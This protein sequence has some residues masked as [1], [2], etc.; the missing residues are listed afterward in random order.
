[1]ENERKKLLATAQELKNKGAEII[2]IGGGDPIEYGFINK[3]ASDALIQV[4]KKGLHMYSYWTNCLSDLK[5][6]I[7]EFEKKYRNVDYSHEDIILTPGVA[8]AFQ[9]IHYALLGAGDEIIT[10]EPTH[11]LTGPTSY[12]YIF[13]SK[14]VAVCTLEV[15][16]WK[17]N[18]EE[19]RERISK[20]TKA[21]VIVNPNNPTGSVYDEKTLRSIVDIAGEYCLPIISDEIYGL[22]TFGNVKA[23]SIAQVASDVPAIVLSGISKVFM[24]PGWR[25]GYIAIHDPQGKMAEIIK[26]AKA[27]SALYG[28]AT[29]CMATPILYASITAYKGSINEAQ[30][31]MQQ[32][33]VPR[34]FTV[35]R[36]NEI[37]GIM[38]TKPKGTFFAFPH[39]YA[40]DPHGKWKTDEDFLIE[41]L[42]EEHIL[43]SFPGS[44]FGNSG[45]GHFRTLLLPELKTLEEVYDRLE[46]FI[47][48]H[49]VSER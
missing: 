21:I 30:R 10:F 48:K 6:A 26:A 12:F 3:Y 23:K 37:Q 38:C 33:Q 19:L 35:K 5:K 17:P 20:R 41:L 11:Y 1:M 34:D 31:M 44:I 29:S 4:S 13:Q 7:V 45:Y 47:I 40:I 25:V 39:V 9:V 49:G 16:D 24:C 43:F 36:L 46:R 27:I 42:K 32:L 15:N 14:V 8:G 2:T 28:H 18:L 22:L